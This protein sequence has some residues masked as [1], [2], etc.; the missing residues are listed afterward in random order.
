[1]PEKATRRCTFSKIQKDRVESQIWLSSP[2]VRQT[3]EG[4]DPGSAERAGSLW[5]VGPPTSGSVLPG[6][7][8]WEKDLYRSTSGEQ[9]LLSRGGA[10]RS[11]ARVR[12]HQRAERCCLQSSKK[13]APGNWHSF[14][15][16]FA[17]LRFSPVIPG[18]ASGM[19]ASKEKREPSSGS[20]SHF[21]RRS[22]AS[23][24]VYIDA[25]VDRLAGIR[26]N[27]SRRG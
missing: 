13:P 7:A 6:P 18:Q 14:A 15:K 27:R 19:T 23:A 8:S 4:L 11:I 10:P 25:V 20:R 26:R 5:S 21:H 1:M 12:P 3:R 2:G 17:A 9:L 24:Q 16:A 22:I